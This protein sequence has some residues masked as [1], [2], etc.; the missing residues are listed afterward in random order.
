LIGVFVFFTIHMLEYP[1]ILHFYK[2]MSILLHIGYPKTASSWLQKNY[3]SKVENCKRIDRK[4]IQRLFLEP[5]AFE[6]DAEKIKREFQIEPEKHLLLSDELLLGRLR[7]GGV[8]GFVTKEVA[9]RLK[10]VFPDAQI[11]LFIR[12]QVEMIASAYLQYVR[13]GGNYG[14][15]KFMF[16]EDYEGSRS[17]RLVLLGLDYF[18]YHQVIEYYKSIFGEEQIHVF[19]YE[20]LD[21]NPKEFIRLFSE[22]FKLKVDTDSIEYT[23]VNPGYR[24]FLVFTRRISSIFSKLGPLNKYY[25]VHIPNFDYISRYFHHIANNFRIFGKRPDSYKL[26][27]KKNIERVKEFY[28]DS[29]KLL[30]KQHGL[31]DLEKYN[32][33]L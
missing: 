3:F 33:P 6:F 23:S 16:P 29:N 10:A 19:L 24:S 12:N 25:L 21:S 2:I 17:N 15:M 30:I 14:I 4:T 20:D 31:K 11:I 13:S 1:I 22:R 8:K 26:I 27:G 5:G 9:N 7:P 18:L 28:K 32:Y